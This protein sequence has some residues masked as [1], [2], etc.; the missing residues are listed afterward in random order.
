[1]KKPSHNTFPQIVTK[2]HASVKIYRNENRGKEMFTVSYRSPAG[3]QRRNF[4]DLETARREANNVAAHLAGGDLEALKLSGRERQLYVAAS[5]AIARTGLS[6]DVVARE[7]ATAFDVLGRD[8]II[9]AAR[10]YRKHAES[11][12]PVVTVPEAVARFVA[13][14]E[15][16]GISPHYRKDFRFMLERGLAEAFHCNL[17]AVTADDLRAYLNAKTCGNVAKNNQRRVIVAMFNFAKE[18]GWLPPNEATAADALGTYKV[19]EKDVTIYEPGEVGRLL[20]H[21]DENFLPWVALIAFGGVRHEELHKG[22]AWHDI[23][24]AKGTLIVPAA[25]AKTNRKRKIDMSENLRAWLAPYAARRGPIFATD[26]DGRIGK[27]S[28]A[29][30]VP[31]KRNAL[32]HSFGSYRMESV[33]NAGQVSMEM[34]NSAA[35]VFKHYHEIVDASAAA[36]YWNLRPAGEATNVVPMGLDDVAA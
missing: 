36:A 1:M 31:W 28:K 6:L 10:Y 32:R 7:F 13:A 22:L 29:A 35:V 12:L 19:K 26:P 3:R 4:S 14:K 25:I 21:A 18:T 30:G 2:G 15:A 8:G 11:S 24:F 20:E 16:E 34:G 5:D 23:D 9:E 33:K 17:S 27:L